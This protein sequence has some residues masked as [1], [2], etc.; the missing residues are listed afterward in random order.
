MTNMVRPPTVQRMVERAEARRIGLFKARTRHEERILAEGWE[1]TAQPSLKHWGVVEPLSWVSLMKGR[2]ALAGVIWVIMG[3]I[4]YWL[5][6]FSI[7]QASDAFAI[8]FICAILAQLALFTGSLVAFIGAFVEDVLDGA[9]RRTNA[10]AHHNIRPGS[11]SSAA[12]RHY[13]LFTGTMPTWVYERYE[14]AKRLR[15]FDAVYVASNEPSHFT[16]TALK[17][18]GLPLVIPT[19]ILADPIMIGVWRGRFYQGGV[20]DLIEDVP[21]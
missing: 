5:K 19:P 6:S 2:L 7:P 18:L 14:R 13:R 21:Q 4:A 16:T 1:P 12:D 3:L 9:I 8:L 15:L 11:V 17:P 10:L 20:W